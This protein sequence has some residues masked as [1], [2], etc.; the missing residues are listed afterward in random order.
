M[1]VNIMVLAPRSGP[2]IAAKTGTQAGL[3]RKQNCSKKTTYYCL[4]SQAQLKPIGRKL[5]YLSK[6]SWKTMSHIK[7]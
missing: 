2:K 1:W 3:L 7:L 6:T 5:N 4:A